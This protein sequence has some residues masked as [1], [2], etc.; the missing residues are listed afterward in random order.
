LVNK[1]SVESVVSRRTAL[2][3]ALSGGVAVALYA[4]RRRNVSG[5]AYPTPTGNE[6]NTSNG[7]ASTAPGSAAPGNSGQSNSTSGSSRSGAVNT[8]R[9]AG[10]W[11]LISGPTGT[12]VPG[13]SGPLYTLQSGDASY[14][15]LAPGTPLVGGVGYWAFFG[16]GGA[17]ALGG[18]SQGPV[19]VTAPPDGYIM[20]GNPDPFRPAIVSGADVV[21]VYDPVN[22]YQ[23]SA[24]LEPGQGAWA[25]VVD[26]GTITITPASL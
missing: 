12:V 23:A 2:G 6:N 25:L 11:N 9:F 26:G 21:Y 14:E 8:V 17:A 13:A 19:E 18:P 3:V 1:S 15:T 10:G 5:Q 22:G 16:D 4:T 20:I 7:A 24:R